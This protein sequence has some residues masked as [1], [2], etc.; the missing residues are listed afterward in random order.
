VR[1]LWVAFTFRFVRGDL[2]G[3][4]EVS[5]QA[6][7]RSES[8]PSCRCEAHHAMGGTLSSMG[9]LDA[10]RSHFEAALAAYDERHPQRSALGSDLGVFAN[11]WYA[12]TLWLLGNESAAVFHAGQAIALARRHDHVYSETLALAYA[13]M[14]HQMRGDTEQVLECASRVVALCERYGFG[15]YVDWAHILIGWARGL[16]RPAEGVEIIESAIDRLDA[17]RAQARRPY[18]LSLLVGAY[19]LLGD[20]N[21]AASILDAAIAFAL[22]RA[23]AWWL[24]ALYLQASEFQ[25]PQERDATIRRAIELARSQN[26]RNLERR[27]LASIARPV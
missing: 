15:Y 17:R 13:G 12:H 1:W 27:I 3:T 21:R 9:E 26:S 22:E 18:Y 19:S 5:E 14:L 25:P 10:S 20:T 7:A 16:E 6:L 11:A 2:K 23:D 4:R 8:D 24:P